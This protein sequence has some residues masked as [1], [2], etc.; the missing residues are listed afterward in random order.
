MKRKLLIG[1]VFGAGAACFIFLARAMA[2]PAGKPAEVSPQMIIPWVAGSIRTDGR[3]DDPLW[4]RAK[5]LSLVDNQTAKR[6]GQRTAIWAIRNDTF[7]YIGFDCEDR[8]I[9]ATLTGRDDNLWKEDAVEIFLDPAGDGREY[10]EIEVNPLGTLYDAWVE[11]STNIDFDKSKTFDM[12]KIQAAAKIARDP[13][14]RVDR[15][16]TCEIAIP[17]C[18]LPVGLT[19]AS[20]MNFTRID[21]LRGQVVYQAWS[22]THRWFH[23][24]ERFGRI[25]FKRKTGAVSAS[26]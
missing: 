16:W 24:P 21:R 12:K 1:T 19:D 15:S 17:I 11:F 20:R 3:L 6:P 10:L 5:R 9:V 4:R 26:P 8:E 7:I 14:A 23:V 18:E 13:G 25:F 2:D 22:P